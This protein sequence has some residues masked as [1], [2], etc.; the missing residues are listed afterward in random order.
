MSDADEVLRVAARTE[1]YEAGRRE[2]AR[3]ALLD[4]AQALEGRMGT[5]LSAPTDRHE[6]RVWLR[7]RATRPGTTGDDHAR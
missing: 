7:A 5:L 2:G 6:F 1:A 3:Q 4:A